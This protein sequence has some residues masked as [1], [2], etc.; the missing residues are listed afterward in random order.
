M[1]ARVNI[2][3]I[4]NFISKYFRI[5]AYAKKHIEIG[6]TYSTKLPKNAHVAFLNSVESYEWLMEL[7]KFNFDIT[8]PSLFKP[9]NKYIKLMMQAGKKGEY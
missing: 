3:I 5:A 2:I 1:C 6:R 9:N 8:E 4:I 7:E